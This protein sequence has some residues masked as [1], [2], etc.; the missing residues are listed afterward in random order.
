MDFFSA[1]ILCSSMNQDQEQ[2]EL[3]IVCFQ[4]QTGESVTNRT[5][6]FACGLYLSE[7]NGIDIAIM[8][9]EQCDGNEEKPCPLWRAKLGF[10]ELQNKFLELEGVSRT[11]RTTPE[12]SKT[13]RA[14][15]LIKKFL[16]N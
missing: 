15:S 2:R 1:P 6:K 7:G 13:Q 9:R 16:T 12:R 5:S 4:V 11:D 14:G 8:G 3:E 10:T